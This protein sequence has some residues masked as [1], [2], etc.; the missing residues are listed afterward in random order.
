MLEFLTADFYCS[1]GKE[2]N[3]TILDVN[4][5]PSDVVTLSAGKTKK[6]L[7]FTNSSLRLTC[8]DPIW[9]VD[10]W[11]LDTRVET[12]LSSMLIS[13]DASG[14]VYRH[15]LGSNKVQALT[16]SKELQEFKSKQFIRI[17]E[18][19]QTNKIKGEFT[20]DQAKMMAAMAANVGT[21]GAA[22]MNNF[23]NE[24]GR[25]KTGTGGISN[26]IDSVARQMAKKHFKDKGA[27]VCFVCNTDKKLGIS[28]AALPVKD[29]TKVEISSIASPEE[30]T[31][32]RKAEKMS[33][34][35]AD[36]KAKCRPL[37]KLTV[38]E[39]RPSAPTAVIMQLPAY[40]SQVTD[41]SQLPV[42]E[43]HA[44]TFGEDYDVSCFVSLP[45]KQFEY[46]LPLLGPAVMEHPAV[47]MP[48]VAPR[49]I[50]AVIVAKKTKAGD[51]DD[52]TT[53][54]T[55]IGIVQGQSVKS[56][57]S[58]RN[59]FPLHTYKTIDLAKTSL[60]P[61]Q[62][63]DMNN[64]YFKSF[65]DNVKRVKGK[66][67]EPQ[68]LAEKK[69]DCIEAAYADLVKID[70]DGVITSQYFTGNPIDL[71]ND[72]FKVAA[73]HNAEL[74]RDSF[75]IP[76]KVF[77]AGT[78]NAKGKSTQD[79]YVFEKYHVTRKPTVPE[80]AAPA[81]VTAINADYLLHC[82]INKFK[83]IVAVVGSEFFTPEKVS[84]SYG[85]TKGAGAGNLIRGDAASNHF[86]NEISTNDD[87]KVIM[88]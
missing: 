34:L 15:R 85:K 79:R 83:H 50:E 43:D 4:D 14:T 76:V 33:A 77:K 16:Y 57:V 78:T 37:Y 62:I 21:A 44:Q 70:A 30:M 88:M 66:G 24:G 9:V 87:Y 22:Q 7:E 68:L 18:D 47:A 48:G 82:P 73:F 35:T 54:Q 25:K 10:G 5:L 67:Q 31:E 11:A 61:A 6:V 75:D 80:G 45:I 72:N 58:D 59:Y 38:K 51:G 12:N 86:R 64:G 55:K 42:F 63:L 40:M 60:S 20:M 2:K 3:Y 84:M 39:S 29:M 81:D 41:H 23:N 32:I 27:L 46:I 52:L 65:G 8:D 74:L 71:G 49:V 13:C 26:A 56:A 1:V 36:L 28:T 19:K 53:N 17:E 69:I